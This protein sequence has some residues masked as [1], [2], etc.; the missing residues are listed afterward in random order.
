MALQ[1]CR[2]FC[3]AL[4]RT[5]MPLR[6]VH[7]DYGENLSAEKENALSFCAESVIIAIHFVWISSCHAEATL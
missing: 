6:A 5:E 7:D 2:A 1:K 4:R 3:Y